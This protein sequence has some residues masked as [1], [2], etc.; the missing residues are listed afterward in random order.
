MSVHEDLRLLVTTVRARNA[1]E[2]EVHELACAVLTLIDRVERLTVEAA[3]AHR[4]YVEAVHGEWAQ[5]ARADG[6]D[7]NA[8]RLAA[9]AAGLAAM[10]GASLAVA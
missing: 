1:T 7:I 9:R 5:M 2:T 6:V 8:A 4:H 10:V 3:E